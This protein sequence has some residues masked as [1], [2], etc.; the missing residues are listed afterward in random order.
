MEAFTR[1][2]S[3]LPKL[4]KVILAIVFFPI[5]LIFLLSKT[6]ITTPLKYVGSALILV[7]G[8]FTYSILLR[9]VESERVEPTQSVQTSS[10]EEKVAP[11]ITELTLS[12]STETSFAIREGEENHFIFRAKGQAIK[13]E[14]FTLTFD[15]NSITATIK[16]VEEKEDNFFITVS[17]KAKKS[18][19][20]SISISPAKDNMIKERIFFTIDKKTPPPTNDSE[21][22]NTS[23]SN[24][25]NNS[26]SQKNSNEANQNTSNQSEN[27]N[28]SNDVNTPKTKVP[29]KKVE[30]PRESEVLQGVYATPTGK[31]YHY[32]STCGGSGSYGVTQSEID[33]RGLTPCKK[34]AS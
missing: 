12:Q 21:D 7:M 24:D 8:V 34:C 9:P 18:G 29:Q 4:L 3:K 2:F 22:E 33:N 6:H 31:R 27:N 20:S 25:E 23:L 16:K 28:A 1:S 26:V 10:E 13:K 19:N 17:V 30:T 14:D 15:K 32:R 5:T 11:K